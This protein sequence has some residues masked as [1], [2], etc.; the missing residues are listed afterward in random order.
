MITALPLQHPAVVKL[1]KS[2]GFLSAISAHLG[3]LRPTQRFVGMLV[4]EI[5]SSRSV[6]P[7]GPI[8]AL[9]FGDIWDGIEEER[10]VAR[11]LRELV[12][13]KLDGQGWQDDLRCRWTAITT[14]PVPTRAVPIKKAPVPTTTAPKRPL[15]SIIDVPDDLRPFPLPPAPSDDY[16]ESLASAD[17]GV[18]STTMPSA[19]NE[20]ATRRRGK[21]RAPV[22]IPELVAYLKGQAPEG[23]KEQEDEVAQRIEMGLR[24]GEGLIRRKKGWGG[25]LGQSKLK[26]H[27]NGADDTVTVENAVD[28]AFAAMLL[29]DM[30]ETDNFDQLKQQILVALVASAPRQVVPYAQHLSSSL[31]LLTAVIVGLSSSNTLFRNIRSHNDMRCLPLSLSEVASS[32]DFPHLLPRPSS[33]LMRPDPKLQHRSNYSRARNFRRIFT[34]K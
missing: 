16:I 8:A 2:P 21:L 11:S 17:A 4:A 3:L 5:V 9:N 22:Y 1:S 31:C 30:F 23:G 12:G 15:I 18:Y 28:L 25:E 6:A 34:D 29:Q 10:A 27:A 26:L 20:T 32:L 33:P 14:H 19:S 7:D 24:E 13:R